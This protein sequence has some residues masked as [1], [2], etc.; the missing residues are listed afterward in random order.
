MSRS[1]EFYE[2]QKAHRFFGSN[3]ID[4]MFPEGKPVTVVPWEQ[5][6]RRRDRQ[7]YDRE[8]VHGMLA[9]PPQEHEFHLVDPRDLHATQPGI[10][11]AGVMH[12]LGDDYR[13][14]GRTYADHD[15]AGNRHPVVYRREDLHGRDPQ[16]LLLSGHH[17]AAAALLTGQ[18]FRVRL[19]EGPWGPMRGS[20]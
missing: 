11:R 15:Q 2:S 17:R 16:N 18:Q 9:K 3:D 8:L 12:Y 14:T 19:V 4:H 5:M 7:D 1:Q 10:T 20:R 6:G 13:R